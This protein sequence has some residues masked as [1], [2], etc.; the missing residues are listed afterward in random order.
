[1]KYKSAITA[2]FI[3][4]PNRFLAHVMIDGRE[5]VV[6]V[7]NTGRCREILTEGTG[8]ILEEAETAGRKTRYSLISAYKGEVLINIDSQVPNTV[9]YQSILEGG[10]AEVP[11]VTKLSREVTYGSSRFDLYFEAGEQ[12]GFIEVK[13]VTLEAEGVA[14]FPDAP[15]QRGTRHIYEMIHAVEEGYAGYLFFLIQLKGVTR[16]TPNRRQDPD[17]AEALSLAREKGVTILAYDSI[18][19]EDEIRLGD[20]VEIYL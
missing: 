18:V 7:K 17:F 4:R 16:F 1:L 3:N 2:S 9:V 14:L 11:K 10:V 6:H 8:V 12:K 19:T 20:P 5:E 13:G 15:T